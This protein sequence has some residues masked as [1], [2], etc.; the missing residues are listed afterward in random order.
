MVCKDYFLNFSEQYLT[1]IL[2]SLI[3]LCINLLLN[4][5]IHALAEYRRHRTATERKRFLILNIF[6]VY[7]VNMVL[8]LLLIRANFSN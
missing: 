2:M 5:I 7:F 3:V 4:Y 1:M 8:L 6:L